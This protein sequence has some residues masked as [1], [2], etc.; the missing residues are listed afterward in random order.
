MRNTVEYDCVYLVVC[1]IRERRP[2]WVAVDRLRN[3]VYLVKFSYI[4]FD[5]VYDPN[6]PP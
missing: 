3:F 1:N 6:F 4:I 2:K 5:R